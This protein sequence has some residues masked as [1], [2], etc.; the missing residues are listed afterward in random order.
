MP[1]CTLKELLVTAIM[2]HQNT[3]LEVSFLHVLNVTDGYE[4]QFKHLYTFLSEYIQFR[5]T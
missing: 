4:K 5:L 2:P 1:T 3:G